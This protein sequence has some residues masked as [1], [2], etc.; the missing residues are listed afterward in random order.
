MILKKISG[1]IQPVRIRHNFH[2]RRTIVIQVKGAQGRNTKAKGDRTTGYGKK[3]KA[4]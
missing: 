3:I 2:A 1:E 4:Y